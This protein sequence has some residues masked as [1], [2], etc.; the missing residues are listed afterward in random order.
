MRSRSLPAPVIAL[1]LAL[2]PASSL[3]GQDS[4]AAA[5]LP[6]SRSRW[7][8]RLRE[9]VTDYEAS[10]FRFSSNKTPGFKA[11]F[12][13]KF[14]LGGQREQDLR[15]L[16]QKASLVYLFRREPPDCRIAIDPPNV[17]G[18][19]FFKEVGALL[20]EAIVPASFERYDGQRGSLLSSTEKSVATFAPVERWPDGAAQPN[21]AHAVV[22]FGPNHAPVRF[23]EI[24]SRGRL[25]ETREYSYA[26]VKDR[27][28]VQGYTTTPASTNPAA[29]QRTIRILYAPEKDGDVFPQRLE[30]TFTREGLGKMTVTFVVRDVEKLPAQ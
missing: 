2:S 6:E 15:L 8:S 3:I 4:P 23:E 1:I 5:S 19:D 22:T 7:D 12:W 14:E 20:K 13:P 24:D 10:S 27:V 18:K 29:D 26:R 9:I 16:F 28:A 21:G 30:F 25:L 11:Y 17:K